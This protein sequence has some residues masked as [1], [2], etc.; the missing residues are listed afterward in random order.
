ML[1]FFLI[2][3]FSVI[4][5]FLVLCLILSFSPFS[6]F[7]SLFLSVYICM[8]VFP[9]LYISISFSHLPLILFLPFS[10]NPFFWTPPLTRLLPSSLVFLSSLLPLFL[11]ITYHLSSIF[12]YF[13]LSCCRCSF[14]YFTFSSLLSDSYFFPP[15]ILLLHSSFFPSPS[16]LI[17]LSSI[18][19]HY[20]L[21]F[22]PPP[23]LLA[24]LFS[25]T[26]S[27]FS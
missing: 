1:I 19:P 5:L 11:H 2:V 24:S 21:K 17:D 8:A 16:L 4:L 3:W 10:S 7:T 18:L 9:R 23:L 14:S 26:F 6:L 15:R 12:F 20:L 13:L 25:F 27:V 22:L